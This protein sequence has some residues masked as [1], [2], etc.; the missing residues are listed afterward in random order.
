[1]E[2]NQGWRCLRMD[3]APYTADLLDS[4]KHLAQDTP[5]RDARSQRGQRAAWNI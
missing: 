3:D 1:M 2:T 5:W 4:T